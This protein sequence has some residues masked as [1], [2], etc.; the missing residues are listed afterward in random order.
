MT[1]KP[2]T[3]NALQ[4]EQSQRAVTRVQPHYLAWPTSK[5][6]PRSTPP[7]PGMRPIN[8]YR[9]EQVLELGYNQATG[10]PGS[11]SPF[12]SMPD[13]SIT[14]PTAPGQVLTAQEE[15]KRRKHRIE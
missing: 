13:A 9:S 10:E 14:G 11:D 1:Q 15:L 3:Q 12:R 7:P 8:L 4:Q 5:P 2:T 6:G